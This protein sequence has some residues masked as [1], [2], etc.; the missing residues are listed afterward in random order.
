LF[1]GISVKNGILKYFTLLNSLAFKK[2][3]IIKNKK[4]FD[5]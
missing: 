4:S 5:I 1:S 3:K 2:L